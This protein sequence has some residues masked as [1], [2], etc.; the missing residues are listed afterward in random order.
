MLAALANIAST[1]IQSRTA[2]Q[3]TDLTNKANKELAE[4]SYSKDLEMWNKTNEYNLPSSQMSR[5]KQA[6][7]N[8]NLIY[9]SGGATTQ[10]ATMPK[11]NAP[12]MSYNYKPAIDPLAILGAYQDFKISNAQLDNVKAETETKNLTNAYLAS[13][14]GDRLKEAG[15]KAENV[16]DSS[17]LKDQ[18]FSQREGLYPFQLESMKGKNKLLGEDIVKRQFEGKLKERELDYGL[19][20]TFGNLGINAMNML[21]K[22]MPKGTPAAKNVRRWK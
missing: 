9:G 14:M 20:S 13:S 19:I 11:Y 10:A 2:K 12:T 1:W 15:G 8:P 6:G 4:Y 22:W 16:W 5:L 7:L 3:N 18:L 17:F 21:N